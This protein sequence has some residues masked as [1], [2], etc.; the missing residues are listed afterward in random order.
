MYECQ[1]PPGTT[2]DFSVREM[3][4]ILA[5]SVIN[6]S[7]RYTACDCECSEYPLPLRLL[8]LEEALPLIQEKE[9]GPGKLISFLNH[10]KDPNTGEP[11]PHV[12]LWLFQG[13]TITKWFDT[14]KWVQM[15]VPVSSK[16]SNYLVSSSIK[17]IEVV[18]VAPGDKDNILY[19][20]YEPLPENATYRF[21][22]GID[23]NNLYDHEDTVAQVTLSTIFIGKEGLER[24]RILFGV[25][26]KP[27]N[28]AF[29][30]IKATDSMGIEYEF[31]D[32]GYWGPSY[33]FNI[34]VEYE[35]TTEATLN[36]SDP[37]I[38]KLMAKLVSV[39]SGMI[40]AAFEQEV[41]VKP[42][43]TVI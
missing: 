39:D 30:T 25:D 29:V 35:V 4:Q 41:E 1:C 33:G 21:S 15:P 11:D 36:F 37:G 2:L 19:M 9:R 40:Y 28:E 3:N 17:A 22:L 38:Y 8:N 10:D 14:T 18:E 27:S 31:T 34:P 6:C 42:N 13:T 16:K 32:R 24:V 23:E 5:G 7:T 20:E 26:S 12:E 43:G